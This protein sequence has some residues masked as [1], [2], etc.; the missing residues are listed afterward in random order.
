MESLIAVQDLL[1]LPS[2]CFFELGHNDIDEPFLLVHTTT[3]PLVCVVA[4]MTDRRGWVLLQHDGEVDEVPLINRAIVDEMRTKPF[5]VD[6]RARHER[7]SDCRRE[8][9]HGCEV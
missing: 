9:G 5:G 7:D 6:S 4:H 3:C 1:V 2:A 8:L